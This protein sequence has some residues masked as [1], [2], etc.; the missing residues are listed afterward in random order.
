MTGTLRAKNKQTKKTY[1]GKTTLISIAP[2]DTLGFY[3]IK[4]SDCERNWKLFTTLLPLIPSPGKI[5]SVHSTQH[6]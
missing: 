2:D 1:A 3:K 5:Q 4:C 6:I